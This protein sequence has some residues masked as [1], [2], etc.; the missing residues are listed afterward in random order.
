MKFMYSMSTRESA[1]LSACSMRAAPRPCGCGRHVVRSL[2]SPTP[3]ATVI[4][5]R[6]ARALEQP[7]AAASPMI[8]VAPAS[9]GAGVPDT[10]CRE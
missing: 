7:N 6:L 2:D 10:S 5:S 3:T 4:R 9:K 8:A 1:R